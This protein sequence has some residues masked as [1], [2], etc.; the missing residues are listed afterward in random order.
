[1]ESER[2]ERLA[3]WL[4]D[5]DRIAPEL[6]DKLLSGR[7]DLTQTVRVGR[8]ELQ[9]HKS[10]PALVFTCPLLEAALVCD[11]IRSHDRK[12]KERPT[13]LYINRGTSWARLIYS[14]VLTAVVDGK[15]ILNPAVF[16]NVEVTVPLPAPKPLILGRKK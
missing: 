3:I 6:R 11:I 15:V 4:D 10:V 14:A 1:M 16:P 8:G 12:A 7:L 2:K 9:R 13:E 5:I